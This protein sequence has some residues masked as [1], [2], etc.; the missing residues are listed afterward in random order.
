M[1]LIGVA[2]A[3][4]EAADEQARWRATKAEE[5]GDERNARSAE[6]LHAAAAWARDDESAEQR[7]AELLPG[8]IVQ[9]G[10]L[11]LNEAARRVFSTFCFHGPESLDRWLQRV[12]DAHYSEEY[13]VE[14]QDL[15]DD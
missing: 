15:L 8:D 5:Y 11:L 7:L 13:D 3:F 9:G 2:E 14:L 12:A 6:A 1:S 10:V 4:A